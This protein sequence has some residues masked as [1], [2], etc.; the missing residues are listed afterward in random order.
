MAW[1]WKGR[2]WG[3][4]RVLF[5]VLDACVKALVVVIVGLVAFQ[6]FMRFV[7]NDPSAWSE[8]AAL[9]A[10]VYLVFLGT[11]LAA[12][13]GLNLT[14]DMISP[15][16]GARGK[17]W[18]QRIL[19]AITIAFLAVVFFT[20]VRMSLAVRGATTTAL[21]FPMPLLYASVPIGAVLHA[22]GVVN[23]MRHP[24]EVKPE[25]QVA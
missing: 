17:V 13:N 15:Y 18:A 7:M 23:W 21:N 19:A 4:M 9:I 12:S 8:E 11:A 22:L 14:A 2:D 1:V 24:R 6:V 10:F 25:E 3:E 16:L 20:G 5:S